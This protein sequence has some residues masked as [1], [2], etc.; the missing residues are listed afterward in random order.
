VTGVAVSSDGSRIYYGSLDRTL[1]IARGIF[2]HRVA[3]LR[4]RVCVLVG[5]GLSAADWSR[6]VRANPIP[7]TPT[8]G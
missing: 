1:G 6:Y 3:D 5:P 2:W 8:C 7:Y 4:P